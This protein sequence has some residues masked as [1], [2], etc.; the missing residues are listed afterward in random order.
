MTIHIFQ[1]PKNIAIILVFLLTFSLLTGFLNQS[2]KQNYIKKVK[3][4]LEDS[5]INNFFENLEKYNELNNKIKDGRILRFNA[6]D[7]NIKQEESVKF[8]GEVNQSFKEASEKYFI[9]EEILK[10]ISYKKSRWKMVNSE[11][12]YYGVVPFYGIMQLSEKEIKNASVLLD[13]T[14]EEI[15]ENLKYNVFAK[16]VQL[17]QIKGY[18]YPKKEF[19]SD[20]EWFEVIKIESSLKNSKLSESY[21]TEVFNLIQEGRELIFSGEKINLEPR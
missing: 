10:A 1:K 14:T 20:I 11:Q 2:E 6:T 16:A 18:I 13:V 12:N 5:Q 4:S 15:K 3:A 9:P 19:L 21:T 7:K 8:Y 17:L